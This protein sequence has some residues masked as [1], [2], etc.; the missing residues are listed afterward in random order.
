[1]SAISRPIVE[2]H[3]DEHFVE[4]GNEDVSSGMSLWNVKDPISSNTYFVR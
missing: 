1:M 2:N 3:K 4:L